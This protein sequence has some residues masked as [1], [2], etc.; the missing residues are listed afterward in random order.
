MHLKKC[1]EERWVCEISRFHCS[2][3]E[4]FIL[5]GYYTAVNMNCQYVTGIQADYFRKH[6]CTIT[7]TMH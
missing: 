1:F 6:T 3:L 5:L 4:G 7:N 2:A